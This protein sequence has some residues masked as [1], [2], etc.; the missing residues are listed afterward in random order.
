MADPKFQTSFIP[1]KAMVE[2]RAKNAGMGIFLFIS[3]IIFFIAVGVAAF[4]YLDKQYLVGQIT[5]ATQEIKEK[6][7]SFNR[8]TIEDILTL[9]SRIIVANELLT[10]HITVSPIFYEFLNK[11]TLPNVRFKN[12]SF[13]EPMIAVEK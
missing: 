1:K 3:I 9:E 6:Q 2:P 5:T 13:Q 8:L 11:A 4:V 10:K 7:D 12:F